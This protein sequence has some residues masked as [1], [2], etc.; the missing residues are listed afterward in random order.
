MCGRDMQPLHRFVQILPTAWGRLVTLVFG[1]AT[2][3]KAGGKLALSNV[4]QSHV[5][6]SC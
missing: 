1:L 4:N 3:Q 6:L 5:E 2:P